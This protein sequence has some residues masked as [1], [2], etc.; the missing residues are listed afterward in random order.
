MRIGISGTYSSGK[1]FTSMALSHYTGLPRTKARTMREILPEAAPG[2]TLEECTAAEL[3]QMIVTRHVERAV[4]EDKLSTGFV[5]DGSSLQEWIYGSVRVSLGLNPSA[6]AHLQAGE[7]VE[8]T[9]ELAFFE[10]VMASLGNSFKKHVKGSFD[11]FVHLKNELPLAADGH[12]PV[13]DQFRSM[14]DSILK[15]TMDELGIPF[16]VVSGTVEERLEQ[17]AS[18]LGLEPRMA[19]EAAARLAAEEYALLDVRPE[20]ERVSQ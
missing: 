16:Y 8:K 18:L 4:Y 3:I 2:K 10:E 5:S 13:N 15:Q 9:A 6:S 7:E 1:T 12:R 19:P 11:V 14:S 17:I 20:R